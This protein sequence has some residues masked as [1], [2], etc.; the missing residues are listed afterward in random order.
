VPPWSSRAIGVLLSE[1]LTATITVRAML[2]CVG[3]IGALRR[4]Q[5]Y[6]HFERVTLEG[7]LQRGRRLL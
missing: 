1:E 5:G 7:P 6:A 3:G 2:I 4:H